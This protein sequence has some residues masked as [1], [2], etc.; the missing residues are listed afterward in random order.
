MLIINMNLNLLT[1]NKG[2]TLIEILVTFVISTLIIVG[3]SY[4]FK[5]IIIGWNKTEKIY[6]D[7]ENYIFITN[8]MKKNLS[9]INSNFFRGKNDYFVTT[10]NN[11][12]LHLPGSYEIGYFFEKNTLKVCYKQIKDVNDI[13][14]EIVLKSGED[15]I[16]FNNIKKIKFIFGKKNKDNEIE[17]LNEITKKPNYVDFKIETNFLNEELVFE[18]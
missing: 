16:Y 5:T 15:C 11:S 9:K 2:F 7:L 17:Y 6:Y 4:S 3:V 18:L 13:V 1:Q 8:L 12:G 14:D 10:T